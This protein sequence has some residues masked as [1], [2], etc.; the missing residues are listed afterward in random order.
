MKS[1]LDADYLGARLKSVKIILSVTAMMT[2]AHAMILNVLVLTYSPMIF[3][4]LAITS[5]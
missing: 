1:S 4:S 5:M 3:L 2:V